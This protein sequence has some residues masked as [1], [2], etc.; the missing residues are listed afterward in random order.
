MYQTVDA[1]LTP[2]LKFKKTSRDP[3]GYLALWL[4][5]I[6]QRYGL[7]KWYL[8]DRDLGSGCLEQKPINLLKRV[9][10]KYYDDKGIDAAQRDATCT[11][12]IR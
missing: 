12:L 10:K 11:W 1:T 7:P 2:V 3:S 4:E 6:S 9:V 8:A 5:Q